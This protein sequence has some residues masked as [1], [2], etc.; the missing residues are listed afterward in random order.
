MKNLYN[1]NWFIKRKSNNIKKWKNLNVI[2][3]FI[4]F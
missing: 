1:N 3:L 4:Y 2:E